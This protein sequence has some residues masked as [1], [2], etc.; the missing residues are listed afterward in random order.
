MKKILFFLPAIVFTI[1]YVWVVFGGI[2]A[3]HPIVIVW[4]ALFL[5]AGVLLS[6]DKF[7]GG[8]FGV[9]PAAAFIYMGTQ[10][11]G[12]IFNEAPVGIV[13]LLYYAVCIY[14]VYKNKKLKN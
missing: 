12:Q 3:V 6:K 1:F 9:I 11:T 7:W 2:G 4:L 14:C 5:A 13:V 8:L 10:T